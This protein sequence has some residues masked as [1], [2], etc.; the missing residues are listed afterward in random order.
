MRLFV[1]GETAVAE[2]E[3]E[4]AGA[5][6]PLGLD[7]LSLLVGGGRSPLFGSVGPLSACFSLSK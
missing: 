7:N 3:D 6:V 1:V 4:G 2:R 5:G